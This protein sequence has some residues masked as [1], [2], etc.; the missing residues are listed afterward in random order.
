VDHVGATVSV[1]TRAL[2][3]HI[4][5]LPSGS[6]HAKVYAGTNPLTGREVR[7]RKTRKTEVEAQIKL[8]NLP[9]PVSQPDSTAGQ[10]RALAHLTVA[11]C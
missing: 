8:G 9:S 6:W 11:G 2:S 3:G 5:Q 10:G 7:F 1:M 4:E